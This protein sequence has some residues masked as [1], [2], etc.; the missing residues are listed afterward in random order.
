MD[1]DPTTCGTCGLRWPRE[2]KHPPC[3]KLSP[4]ERRRLEALGSYRPVNGAV[5]SR[6]S[7]AGTVSPEQNLR[8]AHA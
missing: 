6:T 2:E 5:D 3:L 7:G 1:Q 4:E 8:E